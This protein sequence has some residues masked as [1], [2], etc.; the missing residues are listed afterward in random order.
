MAAADKVAKASVPRT[1]IHRHNPFYI[2]SATLTL[3]LY[4]YIMRDS[5]QCS[6]F[7]I[8]PHQSINQ[9]V[10]ILFIVGTRIGARFGGN[11]SNSSSVITSSSSSGSDFIFIILGGFNGKN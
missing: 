6:E 1:Q 11:A 10:I 7:Q 2:Q 9:I 5:N 8:L 4:N 3:I